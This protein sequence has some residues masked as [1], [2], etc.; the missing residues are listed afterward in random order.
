M[1]LS[2]RT[3]FEAKVHKSGNTESVEI[4]F[5]LGV[6][7]N[8]TGTRR[9]H[10]NKRSK[11]SFVKLEPRTLDRVMRHMAPTLELTVPSFGSQE[12]PESTLALTLI[13]ES[14]EDFEPSRIAARLHGFGVDQPAVTKPSETNCVSVEEK[15][16]GGVCLPNGAAQSSIP[17]DLLAR[18]LDSILHAPQFKQLHA[19]WLGIKSLLA[20]WSD[21]VP[22]QIEILDISKEELVTDFE[23]GDASPTLSDAVATA[24]SVDY[25]G[26]HPPSALL[27]DYEF[28]YDDVRHLTALAALAEEYQTVVIAG[29]SAKFLPVDRF[30]DLNDI[31][32]TRENHKR[33]G[34]MLGWRTFRNQD[35]SKRVFLAIPPV[36]LRQPYTAVSLDSSQSGTYTETTD[37]DDL[38]CYL[39][40]NGAFVVA[41]LLLNGFI[42]FGW[43]PA[44]SPLHLFGKVLEYPVHTGMSGAASELVGPTTVPVW[45]HTCQELSRL[46]FVPIVACPGTSA[47]AVFED[48]S[49]HDG[50]GASTHLLFQLTTLRL[51]HCFSLFL[52]H[53]DCYGLGDRELERKV[54]TWLTQF[55]NQVEPSGEK[56]GR[57]APLLECVLISTIVRTEKTEV[58]ATVKVNHGRNASEFQL[59]G[60]TPNDRHR[61][62]AASDE[63]GLRKDI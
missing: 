27:V 63:G 2:G 39:W 26:S 49:C 44:I 20:H 52:R 61:D 62:N 40:G 57:P 50:D 3:V 13:L 17:N 47:V 7:G 25:W 10:K 30:L 19:S 23:G 59:K 53:P 9:L 12:H 1:P 48:S 35:C 24:L 16:L 29:A 37:S 28:G 5:I 51:Q 11:S 36:L 33:I 18:Q 54:E 58:S 38:S 60:L 43:V 55:T 41:Q 42:D 21:I 31:D 46:G 34:G 6:L 8:F 22:L 32:R 56:A 14:L 45:H 4:P 15:C